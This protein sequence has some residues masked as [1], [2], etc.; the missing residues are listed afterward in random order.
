MSES[1]P[2]HSSEEEQQH[3]DDA[4]PAPAAGQQSFFQRMFSYVSSF[5]SAP[6][7]DAPTGGVPGADFGERF[8]AAYATDI[9]HVHHLK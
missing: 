8:A 3:Q 9:L 5:F 1:P 7:N 6:T 2:P 4:A